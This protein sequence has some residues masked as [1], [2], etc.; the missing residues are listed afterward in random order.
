VI[1]LLGLAVLLFPDGHLPSPRLR[2]LLLV[3]LSVGT[4]WMVS[5][6]SLT[7]SAITGHDIRVDPYGNLQ[8]LSHEVGLL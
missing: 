3:Y 2:W 6:F 1:V 4:V 5:A 8:V 7:I